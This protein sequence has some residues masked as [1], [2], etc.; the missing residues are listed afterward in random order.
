M[1]NEKSHA[2]SLPLG[3]LGAGKYKAKIWA[4]GATPTT[5]KESEREVGAS[6]ALELVLA[7]S[8]GA[9]VRITAK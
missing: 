2:I 6:D 3:F 5:L 8:G 9:A 7:P 4:D 1:G